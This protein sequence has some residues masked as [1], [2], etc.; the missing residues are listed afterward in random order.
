MRLCEFQ[1]DSSRKYYGLELT[2]WARYKRGD[3]P[4]QG[5]LDYIERRVHAKF[6]NAEI[7]EL[8]RRFVPV[9]SGKD[10]TETWW[11][12]RWIDFTNKKEGGAK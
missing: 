7:V 4:T 12:L 6:P 1:I 5:E 3:F 11:Y 10:P 8:R 2:A 9:E